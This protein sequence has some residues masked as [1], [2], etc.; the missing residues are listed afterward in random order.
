MSWARLHETEVDS[1]ALPGARG[2]GAS[3]PKGASEAACQGH[4]THPASPAAEEPG[5]SFGLLKTGITLCPIAYPLANPTLAPS[6][7][8]LIL[9]LPQ[10]F[11]PSA[12]T[13]TFTSL[14][15]NFASEEEE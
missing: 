4:A 2:G 10:L 13:K 15:V 9:P 14:P 1:R 5:G 3:V 7:L 12:R 8:P 6:P 11:A